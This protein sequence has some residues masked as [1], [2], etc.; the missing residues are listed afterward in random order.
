MVRCAPTRKPTELPGAFGTPN[1]TAGS[2][3]SGI[4]FARVRSAITSSMT[5]RPI[6]LWRKANPSCM[7]LMQIRLI[8]RGTPPLAALTFAMACSENSAGTGE[9]G[10]PQAKCDALFHL[11]RR[12]A[13]QA[14]D[15]GDA[16]QQLGKAG[17]PEF[18]G[19][20]RLSGKNDVQQLAVGRFKIRQQ[21]ER[22]QRGVLQILRL[23]DN[24]HHRLGAQAVGHKLGKELMQ[25][26]RV[27]LANPRR[28]PA[29]P[30]PPGEAAP[31]RCIAC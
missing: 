31:A 10:N 24:D 19:K 26:E 28:E 15:G 5:S 25:P 12:E 22:F 20:L 29:T 1:S 4:H 6:G 8:S 2:S 30:A 21:A 3:V 27:A 16:L 14:A 9:P 7:A 13:L 11:R 17:V 18:A 23:V